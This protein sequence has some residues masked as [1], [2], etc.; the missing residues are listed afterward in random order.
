MSE[1]STIDAAET[2]SIDWLDGPS[3][4]LDEV[5]VDEYD[6]VASPNDW[7][8]M[9][10][11]SFIERGAVKIPLFQ[12]NYVWDKKRASKLIE[13]LLL[14]LPIP[15]VFL[16]EEAKNS[17]L[18]IDG[19]Q[20]LLTLYFFMKER[21]PKKDKRDRVREMFLT[22]DIDPDLLHDDELFEDF[23]LT[24]PKRADGTPNKF[25]GRRYNQL[26]DDKTVLDLKTIRNVIVKQAAPNGDSAM[27]EIF[28]RLNSQGVNLSPQEIRASLYHSSLMVKVV[29]ENRDASWRRI[30]GKPQADVR[31]R[32]TEVLLRALAL[33]RS[34]K[35]YS[36]TM[37]GFVNRF[38]LDVRGFS[39]EQA[40]KA[41]ADLRTFIRLVDQSDTTSFV[42]QGKFSG[43]LFESMFAGW[44]AAG[45]PPVEGVIGETVRQMGGSSDFASTLQEGSTKSLNVKARIQQAISLFGGQV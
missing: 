9:T 41:I 4:E 21:F 11:V 39:E 44:V 20:R 14:G 35:T 1:E 2:P 26:G 10:I 8:F 25:H 24:L 19:Q 12:R 3:Q 17:F 13:S 16:Y 34:W 45:R 23:K 40:E 27:F 5:W 33:A 30:I 29:E 36:G 22:G 32:D 7:N 28:N 6:I 15:Q 37:V 43:V 38:C 42:R 18:V 31:M